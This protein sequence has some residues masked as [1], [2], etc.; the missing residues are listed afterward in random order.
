M[1]RIKTVPLASA[2]TLL[3]RGGA[4]TL[5]NYGGFCVYVDGSGSHFYVVDDESR[6]PV[7][8]KQ[9]EPISISK[10]Y[11]SLT[12]SYPSIGERST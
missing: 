4:G 2:M 6:K 3:R 7:P 11:T 8:Y 1:K 12:S 10:Y 5:E 9:I